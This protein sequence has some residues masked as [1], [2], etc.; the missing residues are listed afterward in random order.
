MTN[1]FQIDLHILGHGN[2]HQH[3]LNHAFFFKGS[4][5]KVV[6]I[7]HSKS[8]ENTSIPSLHETNIVSDWLM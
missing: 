4:L 7:Q 3:L 8:S 5:V 6:Y 1:T 2:I